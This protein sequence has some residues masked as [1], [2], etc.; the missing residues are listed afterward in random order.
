MR[1]ETWSHNLV[2]FESLFSFLFKARKLLLS[3]SIDDKG[4]ISLAFGP[5]GGKLLTV[6]FACLSY[7]PKTF[8]PLVVICLQFVYPSRF[9]EWKESFSISSIS[10]H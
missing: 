2:E 3:V 5:G 8:F 4:F 10:Y 1:L 6:R 9:P 7:I